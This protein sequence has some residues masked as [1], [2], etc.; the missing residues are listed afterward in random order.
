MRT[1]RFQRLAWMTG[2]LT[3]GLAVGI[4]LAVGVWLGMRN[5]ASNKVMDGLPLAELQLKASAA[6]GSDTFAIATG[7]VD[8]NVD[9]VFCLDFLTGDLT[10]FVVHPSNG[11]FFAAF[12][13]NVL[14]KLPTEQGKTPKYALAVGKFS[15][16][17]SYT[18]VKP[19]ASVVYV[20]DCNTGIVAAY[21]F[22]WDK[23]VST[24]R[25]TSLIT[26]KMIPLDIAKAREVKIRD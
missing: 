12:Y 14:D 6:H 19:G 26:L 7:A 20:A 13:T 21:G 24:N 10:G 3:L 22:P 25:P 1:R 5:S 16:L 11:R 18:N 4:A 17:S 15:V 2:G 9:A 8:G 23:S